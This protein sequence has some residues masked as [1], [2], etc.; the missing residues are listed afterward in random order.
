[1]TGPMEK[2]SKKKEGTCQSMKSLGVWP[3]LSFIP[4]FWDCRIDKKLRTCI[5]AVSPLGQA[6]E[7]SIC[8]LHSVNPLRKGG[9]G[10]QA[11][12]GARVGHVLENSQ[13]LL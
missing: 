6:E 12:S 2:H 5:C 1:M 9:P 7:I 10:V 4:T 3:L 11:D 13:L 8:G